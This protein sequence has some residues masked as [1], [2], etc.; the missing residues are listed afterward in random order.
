MVQV[1]RRHRISSKAFVG[2]MKEHLSKNTLTGD[3]SLVVWM[4]GSLAHCYGQ[5][6]IFRKMREDQAKA[7][8]K[9]LEITEATR[10]V[11]LTPH[12]HTII[13]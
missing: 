6:D 10:L 8:A 12:T 11:S 3:V 5:E 4:S 2:K 13:Q 7:H 9:R 1:L